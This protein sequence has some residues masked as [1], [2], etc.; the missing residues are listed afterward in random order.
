MVFLLEFPFLSVNNRQSEHAQ[1]K[2]IH[3]LYDSMGDMVIPILASSMDIVENW[4]E[5]TIF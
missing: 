3:K 4:S 1:D 5:L 2:L